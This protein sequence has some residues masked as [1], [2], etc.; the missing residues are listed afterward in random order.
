M[1]LLANLW[2]DLSFGLRLLRR[3]RKLTAAVV[4]TL[5]VVIGAD[6]LVFSVVRAVLVRQLDYEQPERLVQLWESG[7]QGGG[8]GDWVSFPNFKD[9]SNENR[10]FEEMAAYRFSPLTLSGDAEPESVLGLQATDRVFAILGVKPFAGRVFDRGEDVPGHENVAVIS[11][12]LWQRRYGGDAA[13]VGKAVNVDG[14]PYTIVGVMPAPFHFPSGLPGEVGPL[15]VEVW[16]PMRQSPDMS[17]R[18]SRNLWAIARLKT[19]V[20]IEQAQAEMQNIGANLARQYPAPNKDLGV[21]VISLQDYVTG[22]VRPALLLLLAAVGVLLLLACGNI[23]NL[24]LSFAESRR[25]EMALRAAIGAGRPRLV[26]QSLIESAILASLGTAAGLLVASFGLDLVVRWTPSDIPR[27]QQTS[28]DGWVIVLTCATALAAALVFGLAPA[29]S[30]SHRNVYESLKQAASNVTAA[31]TAL[32]MRQAFVAGQVAMA[33]MLLIGAGL[34]IRSL[35]NVVRLDPGFQPANLLAGFINLAPARY[36]DEEQQARFFEETIKRIRAVPGVTSAAVSNSVPLLGLNDQGGFRIENRSDP[37]PGQ[38]RPVANRPSVSVNYF[39]AM[40]IRL[41]K[42]RVFDEHDSAHSPYVAIVSDVAVAAHWPNED[43][44]GK[45]ISVSSVNGQP[46]WREIV[47]IVHATRHFGL[48]APQLPEIYVPHTQSPNSFMILT[49][50]YRGDADQIIRAC[51]REIASID[52]EQAGFPMTRMDVVV[53]NS[54]AR[55]R[56]QTLLLTSLAALGVFLASTGIYGVTA[57]NVSRRTR[58]IGLRLALGAQPSS[59]VRLVLNNELRTLAAGILAGLIGAVALSKVLT[60]FLFGVAPLD[61]VTFSSVIAVVILVAIA[62]TYLPG[63]SA[64]AIDPLA[65]LREE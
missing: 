24:L 37:A 62:A 41:I 40:G 28:I 5:A 26:Q 27:I 57:Y 12:D 3:N 19:G 55:R 2:Q 9:W 8:R 54:Q 46:V 38:N 34:L 59:V 53:G 63:R 15:Q 1:K 29:L 43:P 7:I 60:S 16:I 6:S 39:D 10:S 64:A 51:R 32:R 21:A 65:S 14:R 49:V 22:S 45:R 25:R 58:E 31:R 18:G 20:T 33:V 30:G 47:G 56:F 52:P 11:H 61:A 42:G 4:L 36:P 50:R 23:A 13:A 35:A 44:I 48:E 17:R